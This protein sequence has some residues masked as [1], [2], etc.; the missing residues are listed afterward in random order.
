MVVNK[1]PHR[2]RVSDV[3]SR[4]VVTVAP[5]TPVKT[6]AELLQRHRI[7][8]LPVVDSTGE[9]V[10][11]ATEGDLLFGAEA[12]A[13]QR[14]EPRT[15]PRRERAERKKAR[16][17]TADAAMSSPVVTVAPDA[18]LAAAARLMRKHRVKRLPVVDAEGALVGI[19]S[20][21]DILTALARPD[22]DIHR[23]VIEGV[24]MA[25]MWSS[26]ADIDVSVK[27]GVVTL[28]GTFDRRSDVK[29][30]QHLVEGLDGVVAVH[31]SLAFRWDDTKVRPAPEHRFE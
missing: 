7:S 11:I 17:E 3:M 5:E 13:G 8:G 31:S 1:I 19:L 20:R 12:E 21:R 26:P 10:G 28:E 6:I 24:I 25:W 4:T 22:E 2:M 14:F 23:D 18:H 30:A 9:I 29:I 15:A 27:D 16:A